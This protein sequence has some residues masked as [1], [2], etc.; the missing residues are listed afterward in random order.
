MYDDLS[1]EVVAEGIETC[2]ER[3]TL[4]SLGCD[5]LQGYLFAKPARGFPA[6]AWDENG[7]KACEGAREEF[8]AA[9][10][11]GSER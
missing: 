5:K 9:P 6:V 1:I 2:A 3:D 10:A 11:S 7:S 4:V 8:L